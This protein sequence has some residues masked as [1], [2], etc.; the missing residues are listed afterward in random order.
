MAADWD[1]PWYHGSPLKLATLRVGS[2]ITQSRHLATVFSHKPAIVCLE[3]DGTIRHN[4][5][6]PGYL[7]RI[8]EP[9]GAADVYPHPHSSMEPGLEWLTRRE[10]ALELV[11][12]TAICAAERLT[13]EDI[14]ALHR[15]Q[16]SP[17]SESHPS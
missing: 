16:E 1:A 6:T 4:G 14:A 15:R 9:L 5:D 11:G 13:E 3:D 7:Y 8:A 2:T 17:P 10:L 12:P